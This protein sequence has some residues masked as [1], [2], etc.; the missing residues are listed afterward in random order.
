VVASSLALAERRGV[1]SHG[2]MRLKTY[3]DRVRAGGINRGAKVRVEA[4][5]GALVVL[6]ANDGPGASTGVYATD[7]VIERARAHGVA[8]VV[9]RNASHFGAAGFFT[10]RIADAGLVGLAVCNTESVM[11]APGGGRPV[12]G[13]NPLAVAVPLP[14]GARP[15]LDMATTTASQGKLLAAARQGEQI[16]LGWAVDAAGRPTT[17]PVAGLAGALMPG[18]GPKGFGLAFAIDALL[19]VGGANV[20]PAASPLDGDPAVPQGVGHLF[21]AF[22]ADAAGSLDA[23]RERISGL[24]DAIHAS[25][26]D[27]GGP[28]PVAPGEPELAY[29]CRSGGALA[30]PDALVAE[31]RSIGT[32]TEVPFPGLRPG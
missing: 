17:S 8:C 20:S 11:C 7:V 3:V 2:F 6:D 13:T 26:I 12:L 15:Q 27:G 22:R 25:G 28:S 30:L 5:L 19:A 21:L 18:G 1:T 23:Y 29:E 16:P 4:D 24:V 10:N 9:A 14:G 32:Q 31:L